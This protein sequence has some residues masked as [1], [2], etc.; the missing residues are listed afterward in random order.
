M[1]YTHR[2]LSQGNTILFLFLC[3]FP[4]F[5]FTNYSNIPHMK[6]VC[7][8]VLLACFAV[9]APFGA[10]SQKKKPR[11]YP[12]EWK[13]YTP[14]FILL[15][16]LFT[17]LLSALLSADL[18]DPNGLV[19]IGAGRHD[20]W[21]FLLAYAALFFLTSRFCHFKRAHLIAFAIV[22]FAMCFI[23]VVQLCGNN[24]L[25]LYP[26]SKYTGFP[27]LFFSTIGNADIMG[28]FM[29]MATP[30]IGVGYVVFRL[31]K[32]M[33][34][35][36]LLA[37]TLCIYIMI[38]IEVDMALVGLAALVAVMT[39]LLLRNLTYVK[40]VLDVGA[41]LALGLAFTGLVQHNYNKKLQLTTNLLEPSNFFYLCFGAA[42]LLVA[43]RLAVEYLPMKWLSYK[44]LRWSVLGAEVALVIATFCYFR[45]VM[46]DC[47][48]KEGLV[49]DL[50]ELVRGQL[51]MTAGHHRVGIWKNAIDMGKRNPIFGTGSG[52]F[53][54]N[55]KKYAAEVGYGRYANRNLDFAHN[56]YIHYFC[57]TGILGAGSYLAFLL[58]VVWQAMKRLAKNPKILVLGSA[59]LG[60]SVQ[61]F[62][63]FSVVI[64]APFF[65]LFL[66]LLVGEIRATMVAEK[67]ESARLDTREYDLAQ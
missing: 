46:V 25:G 10:Y 40:R 28:G 50:Y 13:Q 24:F 60:Y 35:F 61:V 22:V 41:S 5:V 55:F 56:E 65:W 4:L 1:R 57:T 48:E 43:I 47:P 3:F 9:L 7:F 15:F 38:K 44:V 20:G 30:I 67:V 14:D 34:A 62:F 6:M 17:T 45:F 33:R 49:K 26:Q 64:A 21:L 53:A 39:P 27:N 54:K 52:T 42:V 59:V 31:S 18:N 58:S 2:D 23:A 11:Q 32:G 29:C 63:C 66:G 12:L 36:F 16:F 8:V 19:F 51:S 37:H